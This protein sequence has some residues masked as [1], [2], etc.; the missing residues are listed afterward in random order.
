VDVDQRAA[1]PRRDDGRVAGGLDVAETRADDQQHVG[2]TETGAEHRVGADREM[3]RIAP[4][5]VVDVVLAAPGRR[6]GDA[7][8]VAPCGKVLARRRAPWLAADDRERTLG[9]LQQRSRPREVGGRRCCLCRRIGHGIRHVRACR[10]DVLREGEHDRAGA[11]RGRRPERTRRELRDALHLVDLRDPL[12]EGCEHAAVVDL[13]EGLALGIPARDLPDEEQERRRVLVGGVERDR[14]LRRAGT[15]RDE[16]D[17]G[18]AGELP[19]GLRHRRGA[20]FVTAR[21]VPDRAVAKGVQHVDVA[22]ARHAEREVGPMQGELVDED[23]AAA[24]VHRGSAIACSRRTV[25]VCLG[26]AGCGGSR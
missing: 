12:G 22:L 1:A 26:S 19:D 21:D 24:A 10:E 8:R 13:L 15:P 23:P 5:L 4:R 2:V 11:P 20:A 14:G 25:A 17:P 6:D 18:R 9:A 3:A 16:A 7:A